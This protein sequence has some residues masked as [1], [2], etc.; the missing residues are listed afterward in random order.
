MESFQT[1]YGRSPVQAQAPSALAIMILQ[2]TMSEFEISLPFRKLVGEK[3]WW[4]LPL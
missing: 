1:S 2:C 4:T 3:M